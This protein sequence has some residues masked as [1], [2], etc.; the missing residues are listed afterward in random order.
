MTKSEFKLAKM[1]EQ[2]NRPIGK[3]NRAVELI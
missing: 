1:S 3:A 2:F